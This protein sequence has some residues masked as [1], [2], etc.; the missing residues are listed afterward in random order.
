MVKYGVSL[1]KIRNYLHRFVTWWV[2]TIENWKYEDILVWFLRVCR[3]ATVAA[4]AE[5][6]LH[7]A[8]FKHQAAVNSQLPVF[9][10]SLVVAH[11]AI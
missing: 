4:Y 7:K 9:D 10:A 3:D 5:G 1:R 2:R 6:L 8:I 11:P